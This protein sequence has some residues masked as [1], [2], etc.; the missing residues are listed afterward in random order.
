MALLVVMLL[1]YYSKHRE[2]KRFNQLAK[3][4]H[5]LRQAGHHMKL[6]K[7]TMQ[8]EDADDIKEYAKEARR[9][10]SLEAD[11]MRKEK[12]AKGKDVA[13]ERW[14]LV[15][16]AGATKAHAG[17][18]HKDEARRG[19]RE[20]GVA[21][22]FGLFEPTP[23]ISWLRT[24]QLPGVKQRLTCVSHSIAEVSADADR[25]ARRGSVDA[26]GK[27]GAAGAAGGG[28][29][30]KAGGGGGGG[31]LLARL[32]GGGGG[33]GG[34]KKA[35]HGLK[36]ND[37]YARLCKQLPVV[38]DLLV[39]LN[40]H[41]TRV[42]VIA[43]KGLEKLELDARIPKGL[44]PKEEK[45]GGGK[46]GQGSRSTEV[47]RTV[48]KKFETAQ[49]RRINLKSMRLSAFKMNDST[50]TDRRGAHSHAPASSAMHGLRFAPLVKKAER[51]VILRWFVEAHSTKL[52]EQM[53]SRAQYLA[54]LRSMLRKMQ[55]MESDSALAH[56]GRG[57][58]GDKAARPKS[59]GKSP[60]PAK[61]PKSPKSPIK[62]TGKE[63]VTL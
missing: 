12:L 15:G 48:M 23:L 20:Q 3:D 22:L 18:Q 45:L 33:G 29:K 62:K 43:L 50:A 8:F 38:F 34:G 49:T 7:E 1:V 52:L 2:H 26:D 24:G 14:K 6:N 30:K 32:L 47:V 59:P 41:D 21:D 9:R 58:K 10:A 63:A 16:A 42:L 55:T 17:K 13:R 46:T 51:P 37:I 60:K 54:T 39:E 27:G 53:G 5:V 11:R 4:L 31:G 61:S 36:K 40:Q 35:A 57:S 19:K 56:L 44:R 28:G 25:A